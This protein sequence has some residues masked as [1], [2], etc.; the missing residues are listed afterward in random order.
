MPEP[1][2][3]DTGQTYWDGF[4]SSVEPS[5]GW[6]PQPN[7]LLVEEVAGLHPGSALDLGCGRGGDAIWLAGL[8]WRVTAVDVS[9]VVLATA[10]EFAARA[11]VG[12][13]VSWRRHDLTRDFPP[14]GFDLVSAQFLHSPVERP[15]ER[16]GVLRRAM[17]A[18][19]P[20][21]SLVV[22]GHAGHPSWLDG[23]LFDVHLPSTAEVLA[24]LEPDPATWSVVTER[25]VTRDLTGPDGRSGTRDD[26]VLRLVR[27]PSDRRR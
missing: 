15:G 11:G 26:S 13:G 10:A 7:A 19:V 23:P 12:E 21:G 20:G 14:G 5:P 8:G 22:V 3:D 17:A 16:D 9:D 1:R 18:V 4:Y 27:E 6:S 2:P 25:T 24:A